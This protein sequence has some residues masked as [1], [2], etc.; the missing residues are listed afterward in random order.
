MYAVQARGSV[1]RMHAAPPRA[2]VLVGFCPVSCGREPVEFGAAAGGLTG[3]PVIVGTVL[4]PAAMATARVWHLALAR[5][6]R[7]LGELDVRVIEDDSPARGL[8]RAL[9]ELTPAM[10]AL[11][12]RPASPRL[13]TTARRVLH[14][15][16]CP[17]VI[18]PS[19]YTRPAGGLRAV[20]AAFGV[21]PEARQAVRTAADLARA[22]GGSLQ[23]ISVL[24]PDGAPLPAVREA[25]GVL[26]PG[27]AARHAVSV[28]APADELV[29]AT[30][31]LD[32]LVMGSRMS[33][34]PGAVR[35][36]AVSRA[37]LERAACPVM[38]VPRGAAVAAP[39][40]R[41]ASDLTPIG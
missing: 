3:R 7:T 4:D 24:D 9:D 30:R 13:G 39:P 33:G 23:V 19:G 32:L 37:V 11:G 16:S 20:G 35:L 15:S 12:G 25:V 17:V 34:P 21:G 1:R 18:V 40:R 31:R 8:A 41:E 38:L 29:A 36:G 5:A 28:G 14:V 27:V 6:R 22:G 2:P 10:I 26:A